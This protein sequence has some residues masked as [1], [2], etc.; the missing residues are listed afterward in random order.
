MLIAGLHSPRVQ[1]LPVCF[2]ARPCADFPPGVADVINFTTALTPATP[3]I[4]AACFLVLGATLVLVAYGLRPH[5]P[6]LGLW[7]VAVPAALTVIGL[8]VSDAVG[9]RSDA[10]A[11]IYGLE[12]SGGPDFY[13]SWWLVD[14]AGEAMATAGLVALIVVAIVAVVRLKSVASTI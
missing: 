4:A 9:V 1:D 3:A 8:V 13:G 5:R 12:G 7:V 2:P 6:R 11:A 10:I 14:L